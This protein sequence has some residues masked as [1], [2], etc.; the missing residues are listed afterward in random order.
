MRSLESVKTGINQELINEIYFKKL[1]KKNKAK[2]VIDKKLLSKIEPNEIS[3]DTFNNF[4]SLK[5]IMKN[6]IFVLDYDQIYKKIQF[7]ASSQSEKIFD[8]SNE[9]KRLES[10]QKRLV[11]FEEEL[12]NKFIIISKEIKQKLNIE[13]QIRMMNY[14]NNK[15][16]RTQKENVILLYF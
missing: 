2:G 3:N 9:L 10:E 11:G 1:M 16:I 13:I 15:K 5:K 8:Y 6:Q 4:K 14:M 12:L 7:A